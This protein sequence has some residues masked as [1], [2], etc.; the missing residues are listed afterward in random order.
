MWR[1]DFEGEHH[2]YEQAASCRDDERAQI[3]IDNQK[4]LDELNR[5]HEKIEKYE[6]K[7]AHTAELEEKY[8]ISQEELAVHKERLTNMEQLFQTTKKS[9][10]HEVEE[11]HQKLMEQTA[12][13]HKQVSLIYTISGWHW[14]H[15]YHS[16]SVPVSVC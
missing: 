9:L 4:L 2:D 1:E 13:Y 16:E 8:G 12:S 10:Q 5:C 3:D 7:I 6:S 14:N 15:C 11:A